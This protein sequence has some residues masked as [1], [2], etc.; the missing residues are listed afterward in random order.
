MSGVK[1]V[2]KW[3]RKMR[4]KETEMAVLQNYI[5]RVFMGQ[6]VLSGVGVYTQTIDTN[7]GP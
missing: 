2:Q 4:E 5:F 6:I 7:L 1:N 3:K